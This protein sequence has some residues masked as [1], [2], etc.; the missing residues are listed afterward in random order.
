M[1]N[2][3]IFGVPNPESKSKKKYRIY[4]YY[5]YYYIPN[6]MHP[7]PTNS[8]SSWPHSTSELSWPSTQLAQ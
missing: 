8:E 2:I 3:L 7:V 4:L 5:Y 6:E 1:R